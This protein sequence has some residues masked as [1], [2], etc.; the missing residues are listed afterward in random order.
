MLVY[1]NLLYCVHLG[2]LIESQ[3]WHNCGVQIHWIAQLQL[4]FSLRFISQAL[5]LSESSEINPHVTPCMRLISIISTA[6]KAEVQLHKRSAASSSSSKMMWFGRFLWFNYIYQIFFFFWNSHLIKT[7]LAFS[8]S[9]RTKRVVMRAVRCK[10]SLLTL[11]MSVCLHTVHE[12]HVFR[13]SLSNLKRNR[14]LIHTSMHIFMTIMN[15]T[16]KILHNK[17]YISINFMKCSGLSWSKI[18]EYL[19]IKLESKAQYVHVHF[20]ILQRILSQI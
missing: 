1:P 14:L 11:K 2:W 10:T 17:I 6:H 15:F 5:H 8:E 3:C 7:E 9:V 4:D 18:P 20:N 16:Y 19:L 13:S 12:S